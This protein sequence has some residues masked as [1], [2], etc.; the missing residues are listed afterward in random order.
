MIV[1]VRDE[2]WALKFSAYKRIRSPIPVSRH[3]HFG[4]TCGCVVDAKVLTCARS[5]LYS[6]PRRRCTMRIGS[7]GIHF[8]V[9]IP[10][11]HLLPTSHSHQ[12]VIV[13]KGLQ[14]LDMRVWFPSVVP[15][16]PSNVKFDGPAIEPMADYFVDHPFVI[17]WH[18]KVVESL[19]F[20]TWEYS[21]IVGLM[22]PKQ[23]YMEPWVYT[24]SNEFW[25]QLQ[26]VVRRLR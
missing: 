12:R 8:W 4:S 16:G 11:T 7:R 13:V 14:V 26:L 23:R 25:R 9:V 24:S 5:I 20:T 18:P 10:T 22:S 21:V 3:R 2:D 15:S 1:V 6:L 19:A 17:V